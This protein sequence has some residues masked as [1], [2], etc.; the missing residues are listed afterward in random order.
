[1]IE[2]PKKAWSGH[3]ALQVFQTRESTLGKTEIVL[4]VE[5]G[6]RLQWLVIKRYPTNFAA[7][8]G[9]V[10]QRHV[11]QQAG[12]HDSLVHVVHRPEEAVHGVE[13]RIFLSG[14]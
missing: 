3:E 4:F 11:P 14:G 2:I 6:C 9:V 7:L 5:L 13:K 8:L 10:P 1:M 12:H